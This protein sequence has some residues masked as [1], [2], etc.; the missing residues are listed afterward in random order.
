[1]C[2]EAGWRSITWALCAGHL[3]WKAQTLVDSIQREEDADYNKNGHALS[4][5][6]IPTN[7]TVGIKRLPEATPVCN[8]L[9][10]GPAQ[11][12]FSGQRGDERTEEQAWDQAASSWDQHKGSIAEDP[13]KAL[14][15]V[16]V[17][18]P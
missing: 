16:P 17:S 3:L 4:H 12:Q 7:H 15:W 1:M 11:R 8:A 9:G 2:Y 10:K 6:G 13:C 14:Q 18:T 5:A